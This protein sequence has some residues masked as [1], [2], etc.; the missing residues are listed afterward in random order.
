MSKTSHKIS[1]KAKKRSGPWKI[2]CNRFQSN[3]VSDI[4]WSK[5]QERPEHERGEGCMLGLWPPLFQ[6][7]R[8]YNFKLCGAVKISAIVQM[9][10]YIRC[11]D[12]GSV[13]GTLNLNHS[14]VN[15]IMDMRRNVLRWTIHE[16][17]AVVW[18]HR[19]ATLL[20]QRRG[21]Q[22]QQR[23]FREFS[24]PDR[25]MLHFVN[26]VALTRSIQKSSTEY[27]VIP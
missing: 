16:D 10:A 20:F 5:L 15:T 24:S 12:I 23:V 14:Q 25:W 2:K 11:P 19:E 1:Q 18:L 6:H 4:E 22:F 21:S 26:E 3:A 8:F 27:R 17:A 7:E 9:K 13:L